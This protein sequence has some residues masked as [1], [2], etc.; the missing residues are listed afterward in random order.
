MH[1]TYMHTK[2]IEGSLQGCKMPEMFQVRNFPW[3]YMEIYE[4]IWELMGMNWTFAKQQGTW[5]QL[6]KSYFSIRFV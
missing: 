4:N 1:K 3:E 5:M 2:Q 6:N